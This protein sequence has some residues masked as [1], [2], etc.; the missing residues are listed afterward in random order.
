MKIIQYDIIIQYYSIVSLV[1]ASRRRP[2][3]FEVLLRPH[4]G[5]AGPEFPAQRRDAAELEA[6][7]GGP[8]APVA[9]E[10]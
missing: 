9:L 4:A 6:Q 2:R 3:A 7:P 8:S 1:E 10:N 5:A